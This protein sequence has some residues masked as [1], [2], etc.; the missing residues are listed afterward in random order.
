MTQAIEKA[1]K[2][3]IHGT[4]SLPTFRSQ[5]TLKLVITENDN[6]SL[7]QTPNSLSSTLIEVSAKFSSEL[8]L[9]MP[10]GIT[11]PMG[12]SFLLVTEFLKTYVVSMPEEESVVSSS[13]IIR[14][15]FNARFTRLKYNSYNVARAMSE[16]TIVETTL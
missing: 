14:L 1:R 10:C 3:W 11:M 7:D 5:I 13:L 2:P 6:N 9:F 15:F 12:K 8:L 4:V 16:K